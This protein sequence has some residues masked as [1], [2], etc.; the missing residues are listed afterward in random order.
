MNVLA[1]ALLATRVVVWHTYRADEQTALERA[2]KAYTLKH[3]DVVIEPVAMPFDGFTAKLESAIPHGNGPDLFVASHEHLGEWARA[4]LVTPLESLVAPGELGAYLDGTI[5]P[6]RVGPHLYGLPLTFK[7][8]A[9]FYRTDRIAEPPADTDALY[10]LARAMRAQDRYALAYESGSMFYHA[11]LLHGFGG[12]ILD[13]EGRPHLD[14]PESVAALAWLRKLTD[15]Q[16]LPE[17]ATNTVASQLFN[18]GEAAM[19]INGPWFV[20]EIAA[21]VPWKVAPLPLVTAT[22]KRMRP[23]LTIEALLVAERAHAPKEALA[24]A[25]WLTGPEGAS[26]RAVAGKQTV[27]AR[28]AW[29]LPEIKTDAVLQAFRLQLGD[30]LPMSNRPEMNAV[31]EPAQRA[32]RRVLR[33]AAEP[34]TA[35]HDAQVQILETLRPAPPPAP[36]TPYAFLFGL[37]GLGGA[38]WAVRRGRRRGGLAEVRRQG[39]A[40]AYLGPALIAMGVLVF[41]PFAVGAGMS[42]Y[43]HESGHWTFIGLTNFTDI[44]ASREQ[45]VWAPLSFYFTL[46]VTALWTVANVALHVAIGVS[47]ALLLRDPLLKLRGVYRMLLIVPWAVPNFVTALIWKGMFHRQFGA[48]NA[49]L[50][51]LHLQ[52]VSWFSRFWTAF[53][54]NLTTNVWLGFP[55][56]MVVALGALGNIPRELEEAAALDGATRWQRLRH[57]VLPL[58]WPAILPSVLLGAIWT[59]NMFNIVFLVSGGEPD[60]A[61][62]ILVTQ[63]YR[64]AFTRGHR[65]GYA[66]AFAVLILVVLA[67]QTAIARRVGEREAT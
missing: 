50:V 2:A 43:H 29:E 64:W 48:V 42:L 5:E 13:E 63:A 59:F 46:V 57:I 10:A 24:F 17:E 25:R 7:S 67:I 34:Q 58:L 1:V 27:A 40:Y 47:L 18:D 61:T 26:I 21:G 35:L 39:W 44:L 56:M 32:L 55:F 62:E 8:L 54:A 23:L 11:A 3:P 49:L 14:S 28:A 22:G 37:L 66:A 41:V 60:G 53:T 65:Y 12:R 20:G 31:W 38:A 16:L 6:L 4:E 30:T 19:T 52:P 51:T 36:G 15:E 45:P 33:G 9:L